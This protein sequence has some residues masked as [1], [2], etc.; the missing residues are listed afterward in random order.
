MVILREHLPASEARK[1]ADE[2]T[3]LM[4]R[5]TLAEHAFELGTT[6]EHKALQKAYETLIE[7]AG[8]K[9]VPVDNSS[10]EELGYK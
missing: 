5:A 6:V 8:P 7:S 3:P 4:E 9:F 10:T 2:L 1:L